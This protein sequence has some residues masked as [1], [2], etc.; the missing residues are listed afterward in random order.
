MKKLIA[1]IAIVVL[2]TS[3]SFAA[4]TAP[5]W[6]DVS[7][8]SFTLNVHCLP[9]V[10]MTGTPWLGDFFQGVTSVDPVTP[11]ILTWTLSNV[12]AGQVFGFTGSVRA[13]LPK[14]GITVAVVWTGFEG[15]PSYTGQSGSAPWTV[16][17]ETIG[18]EGS[19]VLSLSVT[20]VT[21]PVG[22]LPGP[23]TIPVDVTING[24][25]L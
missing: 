9:G 12:G 22:Q 8:N 2:S 4:Y 23:Y 20:S 25:T 17:A 1:L 24:I 7:Q 13:S 18:C 15:F 10:A 3:I 16:P 21:V 19:H 5:V 11:N 6:S 14:A